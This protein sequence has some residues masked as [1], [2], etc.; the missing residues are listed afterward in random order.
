LEEGLLL[1]HNR[2]PLVS[3]I[4]PTL[5]SG[6]FLDETLR[7]VASQTY[8]LEFIE[9][10]VVDGGSTD[11][12]ETI[13]KRYPHVRFYRKSKQGMYEAINFGL[14]RANGSFLAYLNS[15]DLYFVD[16]VE[17]AVG[18]FERHP[19]A[20]LV[21]GD[22][23]IIDD[24]GACLYTYRFPSFSW[25]LFVVMDWSSIP[26]PTTFWRRAVHA[27]VGYFDGSYKMAG[28]FDFFVRV[29]RR[30]KIIHTKAVMAQG[31]IHL[32]SLTATRPDVNRSE[33]ARIHA[34]YGVDRKPKRWMLKL[35]SEVRIKGKN[36]LLMIRKALF[37]ELRA[38]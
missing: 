23:Q 36:P 29:G 25:R 7:S 13:V 1:S 35:L 10:I 6:A 18:A 37:K 33:V 26:Q 28:D 30:L 27:K 3:I 24:K 14:R 21:F 12:T 15:D 8:G 17:R 16:T 38:G 31:R 34:T 5:N 32:A 9:H 22:W 11:E 4:T 20:D 19:E 2:K